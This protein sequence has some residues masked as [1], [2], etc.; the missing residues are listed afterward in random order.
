MNIVLVTDAWSPQIN[1]VVR[2]LTH[3]C[4]ELRRLGHTVNVI[5]PGLFRTLPCPSYPEIRLAVFPRRRVHA[6]LDAAQPDVVH[7]ATEG[8]LGWAARA[9]CRKRRFPFTTSFHTQFPEYLWLRTRLPLALGYRLM[10]WFHAPARAVMVATPTV[11]RHLAA[12]GFDNLALWS[13]GVDT[14]LFHPRAKTLLQGARPRFMYMGR[15]AVEKNIEAF[16]QL[17][18][19]GSKYVVGDGPDLAM[20]RR[21]YPGVHFTGFKTGDELATHLAN[22]DVFVFPSRTDTFGLVLIEALACGVPVAALPVQG[23][24]DI[25][26]HGVTGCLDEDLRS[27]ALGALQIDPLRCRAQALNY[28]WEACARQFFGHLAP[29]APR[30][31]AVPPPL[32]QH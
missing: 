23:P 10:R 24:I 19:P 25:I 21:R 22:A 26:E 7:I 11:Y 3:T 14:Q 9:W 5:E 12:R 17:D 15:V 13:R 32:A 6:I 2:T 16:L 30:A 18:L 28:T 1:G 4:A 20:L 8:P 29:R 31:A 27:A